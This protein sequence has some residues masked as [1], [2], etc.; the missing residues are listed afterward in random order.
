M[1]DYS[2]KQMERMLDF[3]DHGKEADNGRKA[4]DELARLTYFLDTEEG[5]TAW[6]D[7]QDLD[8]AANRAMGTPPDIDAEWARCCRRHFGAQ[9]AAP[10]PRRMT[11]AWR[12]GLA[13]ATAAAAVALLLLLNPFDSDGDS[14]H[15]A[16]PP[17]A[18]GQ[19]TNAPAA[20]GQHFT[21]HG[22][23]ATAAAP[24]GKTKNV[25]LPDGTAVCLNA[26]SRLS[27]PE[28]FDGRVRKVVL[29]GEG[30]FSVSHDANRP[31][32]IGTKNVTARVL[33]TQLNIRCYDA[34]DVHVTLVEGLV[35][36]ECN[37]NKVKMQPNQ[38]AC[39]TSEGLVVADVNTNDFT[40][41]REGLV[42]FDRATLRT[43]LQQLSAWYDV[44]VVCPDTQLLNRHFHYMFY[45]SDGLA[46]AI[47]LLNESSHLD[48]DV[49]DNTISVK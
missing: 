26:K 2:E 12:W 11:V 41:W 39:L 5:Q 6:T 33:G 23:W 48:I 17:A 25:V 49:A 29:E 20:D 18:A 36:V 19:D 13:A 8:E 3:I 16:M 47:K 35:E 28:P 4:A 1:S 42:Y 38:D 30:Y 7:M 32:L 37:I 9:A 10:K 27:W 31:F 24:A 21:A 46:E 22:K 45:T 44:S 14:T 34:D 43:I 40:S 15:Q